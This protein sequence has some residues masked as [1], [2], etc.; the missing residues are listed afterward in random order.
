MGH[1]GHGPLG[2]ELGLGLGLGLGPELGLWIGL[3]SYIEIVAK[4]FGEL[5]VVPIPFS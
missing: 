4:L 1:C 3:E 5:R 2:L